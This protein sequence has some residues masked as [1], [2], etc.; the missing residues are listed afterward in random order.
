MN[1]GEKGIIYHLNVNFNISA[2]TALTLTFTRP[3]GSTFTG[4]SPDVTAPAVPVVTELGTFAANQYAKYFIK[5]GDLTV[6]GD[7]SVRLTFDN[8]A[9][10]PPLRLVSDIATFTVNP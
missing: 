4:T 2:F 3:D 1:A 9:A 5:A 6:E 7:Y 10:V 8:T